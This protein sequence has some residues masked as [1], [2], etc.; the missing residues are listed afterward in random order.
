MLSIMTLLHSDAEKHAFLNILT[1]QET[2][3]LERDIV[4]YKVALRKAA[5]ESIEAVVAIYS[6]Q[7][8][9]DYDE[10][11]CNIAYKAITKLLPAD[12]DLRNLAGK[13]D[14]YSNFEF[15]IDLKDVLYHKNGGKDGQPKQA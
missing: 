1:V 14:D 13:L 12:S 2:Q 8:L 10:S 6:Y 5:R 3:A 15:A 7:Q 9:S 11:L 4:T